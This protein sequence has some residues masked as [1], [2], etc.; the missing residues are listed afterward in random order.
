MQLNLPTKLN[1]SRC[2]NPLLI[3]GFSLELDKIKNAKLLLVLDV[4]TQHKLD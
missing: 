2:S 4:E 1:A 3:S